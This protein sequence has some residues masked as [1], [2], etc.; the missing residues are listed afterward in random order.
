MKGPVYFVFIVVALVALAGLR[1]IAH[2]NAPQHA[3]IIMGV[4]YAV[5][6]GAFML[7]RDKLSSSGVK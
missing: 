4:A 6:I 2:Y 3:G 5:L 1:N 7:L